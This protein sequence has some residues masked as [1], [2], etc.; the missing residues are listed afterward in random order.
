VTAVD[1][2]VLVAGVLVVASTIASA[3]RTVLLPRAVPARL[4][5]Y[6]FLL[7]RRVLQ[8]RIG[9]R[10]SYERADDVMALYAP[11][12]S[13]T[14]VVTWLLAV[15]AGCAAVLWA[16]GTHPARAALT[17]SGSSLL[18]LGFERPSDLP[19]LSVAFAEAAMG[20]FL[21]ALFITFLPTMYSTF[22][23][24][25]RAV[26]HLEA[27]AGSPPSG[28]EMLERYWRIEHFEDLTNV[29]ERWE[30]WFVELQETHTSFPSLVF[31]RSPLPSH[32]WV[33]AA[34]AV[35]DAASLVSSTVAVPREP[36]A[37]LMIR[38]GYIALRRICDFFRVPYDPD[39]SPD[40]PVSVTREQF[41][42]AYERLRAAGVP[43]KEPDEAWRAFAGWRVN[44]D[45][46][47]V[48]LARLTFAPPAP[49]LG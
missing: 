22:S 6:V 12:G 38:A 44:Y 27:R 26:S 28:V 5:R 2:A 45:A 47:L 41:D 35:L 7:V 20:L 4:T 23:R 24:R 16:L 37:E 19:R 43:L 29:W 3:I 36:Q 40:D 9:R 39:P 13:L 8:L 15:F 42:A 11:L 34:G 30:G 49:W 10:S 1:V 14:L 17:L 18:T 31:F 46:E 32:S 33:T 21:V 25:E 48:A